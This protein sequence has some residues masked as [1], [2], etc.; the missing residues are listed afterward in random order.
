MP[1]FHR[2]RIKHDLGDLWEWLPK[3]SLEHD[4]NAYLKAE[5]AKGITQLTVG[6]KEEAVV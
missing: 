6:R 2:A 5:Q 1:A 3:G 4:P